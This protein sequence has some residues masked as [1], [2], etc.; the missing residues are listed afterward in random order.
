MTKLIED[1]PEDKSCREAFPK[2][3]QEFDSNLRRANSS[4]IGHAGKP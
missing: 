1:C 2:L 3:P 4:G